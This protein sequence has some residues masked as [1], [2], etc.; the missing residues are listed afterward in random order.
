MAQIFFFL[1]FTIICLVVFEC[2][3]FVPFSIVSINRTLIGFN[4]DWQMSRP[5]RASHVWEG[6]DTYGMCEAQ[7]RY[8]PIFL[9]LGWCSYTLAESNP[10]HEHL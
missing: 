4:P 7:V 2:K 6:L 3:I 9:K 8:V 5:A 1:C 10:N